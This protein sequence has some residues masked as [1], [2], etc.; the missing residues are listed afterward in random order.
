[1]KL[2]DS[3]PAWG[4]RLEARR[5]REEAGREENVS[6]SFQMASTPFGKIAKHLSGRNFMRKRRWDNKQNLSSSHLP[7][8][9]VAGILTSVL[10]GQNSRNIASFSS[11]FSVSPCL[12]PYSAG[13]ESC[14]ALLFNG[15]SNNKQGGMI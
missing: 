6:R 12:E 7:P 10:R 3:P 15:R 14:P 1:M 5:H 4:T 8:R 13:G 11:V 2:L 9:R